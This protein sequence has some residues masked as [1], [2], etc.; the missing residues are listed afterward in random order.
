[1]FRNRLADAL[2]SRSKDRPDGDLSKAAIKIENQKRL[3]T[4]EFQKVYESIWKEG[5][6][7]KYQ[8]PGAKEREAPIIRK[9]P[10]LM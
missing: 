8:N 7:V 6:K 4:K 1:M 10:T 9:D 5:P 3:S 2:K